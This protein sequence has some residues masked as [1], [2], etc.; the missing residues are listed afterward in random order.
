MT[1]H[2][3]VT[4]FKAGGWEMTEILGRLYNPVNIYE[5]SAQKPPWLIQVVPLNRQNDLFESSSPFNK[6]YPTSTIST[7]PNSF[8][9]NSCHP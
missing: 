4:I 3:T 6:L 8:L 2:Y 1:L 7:V 5:T 9:L